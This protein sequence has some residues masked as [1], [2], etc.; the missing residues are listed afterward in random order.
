MEGV[1]GKYG[2]RGKMHTRSERRSLKV[3]AKSKNLGNRVA[4]HIN[5]DLNEAIWERDE[6]SDLAHYKVK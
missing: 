3:R 1:R 2:R 6:W 5:M 4:D